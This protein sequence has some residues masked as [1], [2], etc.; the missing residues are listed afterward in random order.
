MKKRAAVGVI[1]RWR[2]RKSRASLWPRTSAAA[3]A[4]VC[5]DERVE[6]FLEG[7]H[8]CHH[9]ERRKR[10]GGDH[11]IATAVVFGRH[12][13]SFQLTTMRH[14][15]DALRERAPH[16]RAWQSSQE[17]IGRASC[18]EGWCQYV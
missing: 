3:A 6:H 12:H 18:R 11:G 10:R 5:I 4:L 14:R 2:E 16:S 7:L 13:D 9:C 8:A 1:Q 15:D 17:E